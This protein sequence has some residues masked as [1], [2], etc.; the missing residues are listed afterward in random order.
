MRNRNFTSFAV[1]AAVASVSMQLPSVRAQTAPTP[2]TLHVAIPA[3]I[4]SD[5]LRGWESIAD[6]GSVTPVA[7][8]N[9]R[10]GPNVFRGTRCENFTPPNDPGTGPNLSGLRFD[11]DF[12]SPRFPND[13]KLETSSTSY[14][15]T[16]EQ[17]FVRRAQALSSGGI[18]TYGY[19]WSNTN[20]ADSG[21]GRTV[22]IVGE[23]IDLYR[24]KYGVTNV[25]FDDASGVCPNDTRRAM[26]DLARS[27]GAKVILNPGSPSGACLAN[28]ADVVVNFEGPPASYFAARDA[29]IANTSLMRRTNPNVKMWHII[30]AA[31]DADI[32]A[33]VA[34]AQVSSDYLFITDDTTQAHGCDRGNSNLDS[35]YGTWPIVRQD[36]PACAGRANGSARTWSSIV[37]SITR[38]AVPPST[39]STPSTTTATSTVAPASIVLTATP[40]TTAIPSTAIPSTAIPSTAIPSTAIPSTAI[41][42]AATPSTATPSPAATA[43]PITSTT[44]PRAVVAATTTPQTKIRPVPSYATIPKSARSGAAKKPTTRKKVPPKK[45]TTRSRVAKR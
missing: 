45:K 43:P 7:V 30:Y 18:T 23:E 22:A 37:D 32:E 21:C 12:V 35:L 27:K 41:P 29:V 2:N 8:I 1:V 28:E 42:S 4:F 19:V 20:G 39:T 26:S 15:A 14:L 40:T 38:S 33:I 36:V 31:T 3:Y 10:N 13:P 17:Q 34:Q 16:L 44:A 24:Q 6:R 9:P 11:D 5:D 25:F